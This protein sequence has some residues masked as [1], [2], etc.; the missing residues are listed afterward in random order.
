MSMRIGLSANEI[1]GGIKPI[2]LERLSRLCRH[3]FLGVCCLKYVNVCEGGWLV[4]SS[5]TLY[6]RG[7]QDRGIMSIQ[8]YWCIAGS[9]PKY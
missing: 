7:Y 5:S 9:G 4:G 6:Q 8:Q 1:D 2:C 3:S